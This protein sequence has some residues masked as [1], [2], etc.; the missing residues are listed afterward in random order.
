[1]LT[2]IR[3]VRRGISG[4]NPNS[5]EEPQLKRWLARHEKKRKTSV[6]PAQQR[7]ESDG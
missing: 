6:Q 7:G 5:D 1:M 4:L 3:T 2:N